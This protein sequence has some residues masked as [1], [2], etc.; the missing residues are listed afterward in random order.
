M[1]RRPGMNPLRSLL[2][3]PR[4][5]VV[6]PP[7]PGAGAEHQD[8]RD[9]GESSQ[10]PPRAGKGRDHPSP[11]GL[12]RPTGA[13][14]PAGG[15]GW[16]GT[17][18]RRVSRGNREL[19]GGSGAV[20]DGSGPEPVPPSVPVTEFG[21]EELGDA[22]GNGFRECRNG[23]I[24]P[25][26]ASE[27]R[28]GG[29]REGSP[30]P[31]GHVRAPG[32]AGPRG[33]RSLPIGCAARQSATPAGVPRHY[34]PGWRGRRRPPEF[35]GRGRDAAGGE[36]G[37]SGSR[38]RSRSRPPALPSLTP[39]PVHVPET[40][41]PAVISRSRSVPFLGPGSRSSSRSSIPAAVAVPGGGP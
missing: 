21:T 2:G 24:P 28:H 29:D 3:V 38:S 26:T 13:P 5:P 7:P 1:P 34:W 32:A 39:I 8:L 18:F 25:V 31:P 4:F 41:I 14:G 40:P 16:P 23:G 9:P 35:P 17:A 36:C 15:C 20:A 33:L 22:P 27:E 12:R 19:G 10:V 11:A 30:A 37:G 6:P